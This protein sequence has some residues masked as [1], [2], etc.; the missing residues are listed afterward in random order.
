MTICPCCG[1]KFAG[2]LSEGCAACGARSVGEALP[3]PENELPSYARSLVLTVTGA[4]MV[5]VFLGQTI[6]VLMERVHRTPAATTA[7]SLSLCYPF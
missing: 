7:L 4:L 1:F 6:V 5:L 2:T 3:K